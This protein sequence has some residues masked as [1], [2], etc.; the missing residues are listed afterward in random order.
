MSP[1]FDFRHFIIIVAVAAVAVGGCGT[2][3]PN[4]NQN[5]VEQNQNESEHNQSDQNDPNQD[6]ADPSYEAYFTYPEPGQPDETIE[7]LLVDYLNAAPEGVSVRAAFYTFGRDHVAEAFADA[8]DRGVDVRVVLGNT[9]THA[10]GADWSAVTI[11]R[12]RLGERLTI[13]RDGEPDGGCMGDNIQHNKFVVF[14]ELEDGSEHV[15]LQ[16]S[17]N[18]TEFQ[19]S[20]FNN[21]LISRDDRALYE[22]LD[23]YWEDLARDETDLA[24]DR[25]EHGDGPSTVYFFP[26]SDGDPILDALEEVDCPSGADVYVA[27]AFFTN[28]RSPVAEELRQMD[29]DGCGVHLVLRERPQ[30]NSPGIQIMGN[31]ENGDIDIGMFVDGEEIQLHSKYLLIDGAYGPN[32]D[33]E[34]IVWT[35]SHNFTVSAL[36]HNDESLVEVRDDAA[37]DAYLDDWNELRERAQTVHP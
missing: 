12:E 4:H 22:A 30:I 36:R 21:L 18:L 10:G 31:L 13:C 23:S 11:L 1:A 33:D 14:S 37:F 25:Y 32:G 29:E 7:Q 35:G 24:Y 8:H 9:S 19:L 28:S 2:E 26:L 5:Q 20:Q 16:T 3:D 15:V 6:T 34:R 27:M 17:T